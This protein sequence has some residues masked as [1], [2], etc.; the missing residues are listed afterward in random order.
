MAEHE[1]TATNLTKEN[2]EF[3]EKHKGKLSRTTLTAKWINQPGE[4]A[5][6]PGQSLATRS[7]EV[8]EHWA[9]ERKA[10][11]ATVPGTEHGGRPG[12]LRFNFPGHG[13]KDL[14]E[15]SWDEWFKTFDARHLVF[16]FQQT[17]ADGDQS[18][19]FMFDSPEREH[20]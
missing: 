19:F 15:I 12:V 6:R 3:L 4:Q 9:E 7:H 2:R 14:Q 1:I 8:I 11:P 16:V 10:V 20:D 18:N 17:K 5:D 13:G